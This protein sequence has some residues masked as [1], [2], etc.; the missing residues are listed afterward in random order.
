VSLSEKV[1]PAVIVAVVSTCLVVVL[2]GDLLRGELG[3]HETGESFATAMALGGA[4]AMWRMLS[5]SRAAARQ[6]A[7]SLE[8]S[9]ADLARWRERTAEVLEGLET[10]VEGRF[11]D[12]DLS[13]A[14]R[15]VAMLLLEGLSL[16][17]I[18][19]A[20]KVNHSTVFDQAQAIYRKAAVEGAAELA[21][22]LLEG[23]LL[24]LDPLAEIRPPP[25]VPPVADRR[26]G[27]ARPR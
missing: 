15:E 13:P 8:R 2:L 3:V 10:Y 4:L 9:R 7:A 24:P 23:L 5:R 6:L 11:D 1:I 16:E 17:E 25:Q 18:A 22:M 14:E 21:A 27:A 19:G 12:L 26:Q 20:R